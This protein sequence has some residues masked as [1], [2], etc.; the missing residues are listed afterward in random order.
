MFTRARAIVALT[1]AT[2]IPTATVAAVPTPVP[3]GANQIA[4]VEAPLSAPQVFN[5]ELRLR[6]MRFERKTYHDKSY[7]VFSAVVS[8]GSP[9][10][11]VFESI[12]GTLADA[13]GVTLE[14]A[15]RAEDTGQ[16]LP[17]AAYKHETWFDLPADFKV[18]KIVLV[19]HGYPLKNRRAF[20]ISVPE[21]SVPGSAGA[22]P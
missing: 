18:A 14:H 13:D 8:N 22:A 11:I 20:R 15:F 6:K 17:G 12:E 10:K 9:T 16:I 1:F 7:L 5:G 21:G 2:L 4:A 3:G 19:P